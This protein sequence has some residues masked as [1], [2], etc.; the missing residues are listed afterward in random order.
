MRRQGPAVA[1][2]GVLVL[3]VAACGLGLRASVPAGRTHDARFG[4][5]GG[6]GASPSA[7]Q[8]CRDWRGTVGERDSHAMQHDSFP[9]TN[10]RASCFV[11]VTHAA[12]GASFGPI[13][14]GCGEPTVASLAATSRLAALLEQRATAAQLLPCA[15]SAAD[16][17]AALTHDRRA[18]RALHERQRAAGRRRY[19]YGAIVVPGYGNADQDTSSLVGWRPGDP[20]RRPTQADLAS[21]GP[22]SERLVRA[23][24]ALRAGV[25]PLI[26]VTGGAV[27]SRLI[28]AFAMLDV[29]ECTL[30]VRPDE[31]I[32]EPCARHTHTNLRYGG[33]WVA[34]MG[35]RTAYV[36]T[37]DG[38]QDDYLQEWSGFELIAGDVDSR[39]LRDWGVLLGSWRQASRGIRSGFWFT[40]FRF[41]AEPREG[42]GGATC[43]GGWPRGSPSSR[44]ML[45]R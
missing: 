9:E 32:V 11:P 13:P 1:C 45:G 18:L 4:W 16:R 23:A 28:E 21:L 15:M 26:V 25:A 10:P 12:R 6:S 3:T 29:L 42:L 34:A 44:G 31:V 41:W 14:R 39:S 36:I 2:A 43:V 40:P 7:V 20:C 33:R 37:D 38:L 8:V 30:P 27:R 5:L 35:A 19:P 24:Q 17:E 22:T